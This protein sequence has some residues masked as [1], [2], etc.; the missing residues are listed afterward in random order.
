MN[1]DYVVLF[2]SQL[3]RKKYSKNEKNELNILHI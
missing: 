1:G 2:P 3:E